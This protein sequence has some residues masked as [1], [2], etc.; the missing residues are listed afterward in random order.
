MTGKI[1]GAV[2]FVTHDGDQNIDAKL[3]DW[4]KAN[5]SVTVVDVKYQVLPYQQSGKYKLA[6]FAL[7]LYSGEV[8]EVKKATTTDAEA[9]AKKGPSAN[10]M[11]MPLRK[12]L[13]LNPSDE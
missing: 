10:T 11:V 13:D 5:P 4:L 12:H 1:T 3:T 8:S 9:G 6:K 7:V 2:E